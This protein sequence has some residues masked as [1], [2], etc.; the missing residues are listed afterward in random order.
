MGE[1][2]LVTARH[3]LWLEQLFYTLSNYIGNTTVD[4]ECEQVRE[5]ARHGAQMENG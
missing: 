1:A 3:G 2:H 4:D 5:Y